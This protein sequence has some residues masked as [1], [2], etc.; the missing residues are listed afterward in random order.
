MLLL[1]VSD[2]LTH[3]EGKVRKD[4][5]KLLQVCFS[6]DCH[7]LRKSSHENVQVYI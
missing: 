5:M 3:D 7:T 2:Q 4:R 1:K 6:D